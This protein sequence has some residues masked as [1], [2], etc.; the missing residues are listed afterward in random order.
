MTLAIKMPAMRW[1]VRAEKTWWWVIFIHFAVKTFLQCSFCLSGPQKAR[2]KWSNHHILLCVCMQGR[3]SQV[4]PVI[5]LF[6]TICT[7]SI[8]SNNKNDFSFVAA[9]IMLEAREIVVLPISWI[10]NVN[11]KSMTCVRRQMKFTW[12]WN[13][14][15]ER[16]IERIL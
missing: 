11:A 6:V 8:E 2:T 15:S 14:A 16:Q 3:P 10:K 1:R 4:A 7:R 12:R 9:C 13:T 5:R